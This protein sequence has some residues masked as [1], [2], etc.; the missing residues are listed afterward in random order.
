M[1]LLWQLKSH[2]MKL[3]S[4]GAGTQVQPIIWRN[5]KLFF[6]LW[7]QSNSSPKEKYKGPKRTP[8]RASRSLPRTSSS[9]GSISGLT[10][11]FLLEWFLVNQMTLALHSSIMQH[12]PRNLPI[13]LGSSPGLFWIRRFLVGKICNPLAPPAKIRPYL[14]DTAS[15]FERSL[16]NSSGESKILTFFSAL[17]WKSCGAGSK[18]DQFRENRKLNHICHYISVHPIPA[19]QNIHYLEGNGCVAQSFLSFLWYCGTRYS[20]Y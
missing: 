19:Q 12:K 13:L 15:R 7:A 18:Q 2:A 6:S 9:L 5:G 1:A 10:A 8:R 11:V 14:L 16:G 4:Q 20:A 3:F 17:N